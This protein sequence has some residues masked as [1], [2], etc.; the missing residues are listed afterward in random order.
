MLMAPNAPREYHSP[1]TSSSS[2]TSQTSAVVPARNPISDGVSSSEH[3]GNFKFGDVVLAKVQGYPAWPG[4][5]SGGFC[6]VPIHWKFAKYRLWIRRIYHLISRKNDLHRKN[7]LST[8]SSSF[9]PVMCTSPCH[10]SVYSFI[11]WSLQR[12]GST[13]GYI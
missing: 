8:A 6:I 9:Q 5:V 3:D 13:K 12:M 1:I 11:D 4:I 2:A 7:L 10:S